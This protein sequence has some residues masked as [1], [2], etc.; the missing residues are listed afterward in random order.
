M[1]V[2]LSKVTVGFPRVGINCAFCHTASYR[3]AARRP[4]GHRAAA[5]IA[6]DAPQEYFRFLFAGASDPRFNAATILGEI[7]KNYRLPLMDRLLYRFAIIPATRRGCCGR[8]A[9]SRTCGCA[10][11]PTGAAGA[12]IRSTR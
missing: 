7:A 6:P 12:S 1:P 11:D 10:S 3:R 4:A 8:R 5:A 2:G 9:T